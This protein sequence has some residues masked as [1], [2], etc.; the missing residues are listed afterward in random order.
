MDEDLR[1][2]ITCSIDMV[3]MNSVASCRGMDFFPYTTIML[4][5]KLTSTSMVIS[6]HGTAPHRL[7]S[8]VTEVH[9]STDA[10]ISLSLCFKGLGMSISAVH[11]APMHTVMATAMPANCSAMMV[12]PTRPAAKRRPRWK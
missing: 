11:S 3:M 12:T 10:S 9:S 1:T 5:K 2:V 8:R 6:S 4:A 7:M